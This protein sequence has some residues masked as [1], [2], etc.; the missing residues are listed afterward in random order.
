MGP[1]SGVADRDERILT[2][3]WPGPWQDLFGVRVEEHWPLA[4]PVEVASALLGNF[5]AADF[6]EWAQA[7]GAE[8]VAHVRGGPLD[9]RPMVL[10]HRYG[11]GT[12]WYV[13]TLPSADGMRRLLAR[14]CADAGVRPVLPGLPEGVEAVRRGGWVFLLHHDTGEVE[15]RA[16]AP[17]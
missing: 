3:G 13:A 4:A 10:R 1:F 6:A 12:A 2:G 15:I 9:G 5:T 8:T 16:A 14:V 11:A 7:R 17:D